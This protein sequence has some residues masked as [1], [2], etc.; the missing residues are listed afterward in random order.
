MNYDQLMSLFQ[1][2]GGQGQGLESMDQGSVKRI[3]GLGTVYF[4]GNGEIQVSADPN[5][6][7]KQGFYTIKKGANGEI[8]KDQYHPYTENK[9]NAFMGAAKL[10]ALAAGVN[11][12]P[13]MFG[14]GGAGA[15]V[16]AAD[17]TS[18]A[19]ASNIGGTSGLG[20]DLAATTAGVGNGVGMDS[21]ITGGADGVG[22]NLAN[23]VGTGFGSTPAPA[24]GLDFA[25]GYGAAGGAG[26]AAGGT[27]AG[28]SVWDSIAKT[29]GINTVGAAAGT[30]GLK[31][32]I[33]GVIGGVLKGGAADDYKADMAGAA[34]AADPFGSQ[35]GLY[36]TLFNNLNN[37]SVNLMDAPWMKNL[38][39]TTIDN[40]AQRLS[41]KYGGDVSSLGVRNAITNQVNAV[42]APLGMD[43][44]KTI[45]NAAGMNIQPS[46]GSILANAATGNL[47]NTNQANG[48]Y[49]T[50]AN[51]LWDYIS[52]YKPISSS[53]NEIEA[54]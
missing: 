12:G 24:G 15:G 28:G 11:F 52:K 27:G 14:S 19:L 20:F 41:T 32:I 10:A 36:Q 29:L 39:D 9:D 34:A 2:P 35:R 44:L 5:G 1:S 18:A 13:A 23:T 51:A 46:S 38:R 3:P 49:G 37:G 45:G 25:S 7:D 16:G 40:T 17:A 26:A 33:G 43:Y 8:V 22:A 21:M 6:G 53:G 42:N 31:D 50:A 4:R 30:N 54:V 47:N 48:N